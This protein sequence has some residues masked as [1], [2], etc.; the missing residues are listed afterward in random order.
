MPFKHVLITAFRGLRTH[1][2]RS[3]LTILGIVI[4]VAAIII[5]MSLGQGAQNLILDQVSGL[6]PETV[7]LSPGGNTTDITAALF[8]QSITQTDLDALG[9][10]QNVPNLVEYAPLVVVSESIEYR[11]EQFRPTILG[12][13]VEFLSELIGFEVRDGQFYTQDDIDQVARVAMIGHDVKNDIFGN[14]RAVGEQIQIGDR[15]FKV[16]GVFAEAG[17]IA[18]LNI[19][20][21]VMLPQTSAQTYITGNSFFNEVYLVADD[22]A[23]VE[24]MAYDI[25]LTLRDTH[26][27]GFGEDDDFQVNTQE[28]VIEQIETIVNVFTAFLIAVVSISLVVGGIGIMNIM[29]VSVSERT[30]EIGL[31]K[32]LGARSKDILTQFLTEAIILT[33]IGGIIGTIIGALISLGVSVVL[34]QTVAEGWAFSF[35][36]TGALLG[37]G[38]SA[39]VGLIFGIYPANQAS[40]K[41]PIEA[42]RYE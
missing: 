36:V 37:V 3:A 26:D 5:V 18:G 2:T 39:T 16:V 11:G 6:G 28:D 20:T 23:N 40:K 15:K 7:V 25:T 24:K 32:A 30:K 9:R 17:S 29:L 42:L 22:A 13:S 4:G 8:A 27:I 1:L 14:G 41:S 12:A 38:V 10:K 35:P 31:R 19:D 34:A 21:L 33:S